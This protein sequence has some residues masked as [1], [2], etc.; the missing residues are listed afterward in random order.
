MKNKI[1]QILIIIGYLVLMTFPGLISMGQFNVAF[2]T[3]PYFI[4]FVS[5]FAVVIWGIIACH[6]VNYNCSKKRI[7]KNIKTILENK[8]KI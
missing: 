6:K 5:F 4:L 2:L 8:E 3:I 1:F 7:E